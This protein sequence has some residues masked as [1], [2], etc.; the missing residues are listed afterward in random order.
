MARLSTAFYQFFTEITQIY[1][2]VTCVIHGM[3]SQLGQSRPRFFYANRVHTQSQRLVYMPHVQWVEYDG[4]RNVL[5]MKL[6]NQQVPE[7]F[8]PEKDHDVGSAKQM[9]YQL[10]KD[11]RA[12]GHVLEW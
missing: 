11:A 4:V 6:V 3:Q 5:R 8:I 1:I 10:L 9:F 7:E 2:R 12:E